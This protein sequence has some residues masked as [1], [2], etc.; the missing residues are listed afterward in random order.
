MSTTLEELSVLI[1]A[2]ITQFQAD[3]GKVEADLGKVAVAAEQASGRYQ[4]AAGKW[5]EA[6]GRFSSSAQIAAA[7][8]ANVGGS[9]SATALK[10]DGLSSTLNGSLTAAFAAFDK[11]S[12]ELN[13]GLGRLAT[14]TKD[15]GAGLTTFLTVPLLAAGGAALKIGGDFESAFNR[16]EAAT[17]ASGKELDSLRD[18]A[19]N[20]ALDPNLKFSSVEAANALE[21]LAKNGLNTAQILGGAVDATTALATATG[22]KLATAADITTDVMAG[23]GKSAADA[24]ALVSNITGTTIA[25]KL[26]IDDYRLALG[27][28]GAVAGQMGV[29]FEDF[30]TALGVTSSGFA[31]GADAGTSFKTFI[32]RL[33]PSTKES[34][35]AME[36]LGLSFFD[37]QG[38]MRPLRDIAGQLQQAFKGLSDQQKNSLGTQ[39][40]GADSIRTALLL[41]KDGVKGFDAVQA[42]IAKVNAASQGQILSQGF[43]GSFEAFKSSLEGLGQKIAE[44]GILDFATKLAQKGAELAS[45]LA[46]A[47]PELLKLGVSIAAAAASTG[48]LLYGIGRLGEILVGAKAAFAAFGLTSGAALLPV[49]GVVAAVGAAGYLLIKN[50]DSVT[51]YFGSSGEGGKLFSDLAASVRDSVGAIKQAVGQLAGLGGNTFGDLITNGGLVKGLFR[52]LA[53]GITAFS[54]VVGGTIGAVSNLFR[55]DYVGALE[56]AKRATLG[57][58]APLANVFGFTKA[59]Q[60]GLEGAAHGGGVFGDSLLHASGVMAGFNTQLQGFAGGLP[61]DELK[62]LAAA[63]DTTGLALGKSGGLSAAA[64]KAFAKLRE[65][66]A[67]LGALDNLLG[68][69]PTQMEILERRA[70]TIEK[71]LKSLVDA[72]VLPSSRAFRALADEATGLNLSL[73][74]LRASPQLDLKPVNVKSLIPQTLGDTLP[75]DVARLLGDYAN[76][77]VELPLHLEIKPIASGITDF[78]KNLD[79]ELLNIGAGFREATANAVLFGGSFDLAGAKAAALGQ[80]IQALIASGTT[81]YSE[82]LQRLAAQQR[83]FQAESDI[84]KAKS[85]SLKEGFVALGES[86]GSSL[87]GIIGGGDVA[88]ALKAVFGSLIDVLADYAEKRGK[89]LIV[90]GLADLLMPGGQAIGG[91]KIAAGTALIAAAAV[92]HAGAATM[93]GG[94]GVGGGSLAS[95]PQLPTSSGG[96]AQQS[97]ITIR[98]EA[99]E[100]RLRGEDMAAAAKVYQYRVNRGG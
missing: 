15:A 61:G 66:L 19:Q 57:L 100:Y 48:P 93:K 86:V 68:D 47:D 54:D 23:F 59:T 4:D 32:Q 30:N 96:T 58:V 27:Q 91:L 65:E 25:S 94:G 89:I 42:S 38:K 88:S 9:F 52:E 69:T 50:W 51:Q 40:F 60:Q 87:A 80:S 53:V 36:K 77:P 13:K 33:V 75:A 81:P 8:A 31:S 45:Q 44:S 82:E 97:S 64:T 46:K 71:G 41:A 84:T 18:K 1:S 5:R 99:P 62:K 92:G 98:L 49:I 16:V 85:D 2:D 20:I 76:K 78:K 72:G 26:S 63:A 56:E 43:V 29:S 79:T 24:A 67:R 28:A 22:G 37:A 21:N 95:S 39:I 83:A 6:N 10:A 73:D 11:Q 35:Q 3:M 7:A 34:A 12:D 74:K 14:G 55:Q 90:D 70:S 17:L